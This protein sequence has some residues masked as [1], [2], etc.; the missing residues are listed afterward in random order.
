MAK[1]KILIDTDIFI[2]YLNV[3][4][5]DRIFE[6]K[7]FQVYFSAV[8]RKELLSK[9]GLRD[10]ERKAIVHILKKHRLIRLDRRIAIRYGDL[11]QAHPSLDKEDALIAAT[12]LV[13]R[14]PL[15]TRNL[16][17]YRIIKG[18]VLF[19]GSV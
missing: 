7:A 3:G 15:L 17:H 9:P 5:L 14:L 4:F 13:R 18:L 8:T 11:R 16:K 10:S 12:A 19:K 1:V 2:D 6:G